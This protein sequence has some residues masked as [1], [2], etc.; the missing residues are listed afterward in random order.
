[1]YC[2][3]IQYESWAERVL[4]SEVTHPEPHLLNASASNILVEIRLWIMDISHISQYTVPG[5]L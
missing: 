2:S 5:I 1:M 4:V 3:V